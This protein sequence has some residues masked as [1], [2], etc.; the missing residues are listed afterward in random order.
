MI[1]VPRGSSPQRQPDG[2]VGP[3]LVRRLLAMLLRWESAVAVAG[4]GIASAVILLDVVGREIVPLLTRAAGLARGFELPH[5]LSRYALYAILVSTFA[6]FSVASATGAHLGSGL[7][8]LPL[9]AWLARR[10]QRLGDLLTGLVFAAA[11]WYG[12]LFVHASFQSGARASFLNWPVWP[13]QAALPLAMATSALR[14][15]CFAAWPA[16]R[17]ANRSALT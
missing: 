5:G 3:D 16:V 12:L 6:G 2:P 11:A 1:H 10:S 9:P 14:F 8:Q 4:L 13:I 7:G 15:L 17:P